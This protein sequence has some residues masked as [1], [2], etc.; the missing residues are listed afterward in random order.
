MGWESSSS[1]PLIPFIN[2]YYIWHRGII[3]PHLA[4]PTR[5]GS[6]MHTWEVEACSIA[7]HD[8]LRLL[9]NLELNS[10][11]Q[12]LVSPGL[13]STLWMDPY[14]RISHDVSRG[15]LGETH[16]FSLPFS[17]VLMSTEFVLTTSLCY[18]YCYLSYR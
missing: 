11:S 13:S 10:A 16:I 17:P 7:G 15:G 8:W 6:C 2:S 3:T 14:G 1:L 5:P 18:R 9:P 12:K 4:A